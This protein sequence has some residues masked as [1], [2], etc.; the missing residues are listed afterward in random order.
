M[1]IYEYLCP[2]CGKFEKIVPFK[3][4]DT[5]QKCPKCGTLRPRAVSRPS[6]VQWKGGKPS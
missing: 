3:A 2:T 1:P 6:P 4:V 5:P